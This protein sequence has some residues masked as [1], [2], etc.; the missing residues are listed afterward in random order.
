MRNSESVME[1]EDM[2]E[3]FIEESFSKLRSELAFLF[4]QN[5]QR[6]G[7]DDSGG[8][9]AALKAVIKTTLLVVTKSKP[10]LSI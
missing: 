9:G 5:F 3:Q 10:K 1:I 4:V 8:G 7:N 6:I 2:T